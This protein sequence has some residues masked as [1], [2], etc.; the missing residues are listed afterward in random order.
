[1]T[2][3][4]LSI[5]D[6]PPPD[7]KVPRRRAPR[8]R[9]G[10]LLDEAALGIG[11]RPARLIL[12]MVGTVAGIAALV[13]TLGLG[14]TAG[15]QIA[16]RF[17]AAAAT[18]VT[19]TMPKPPG[20][21]GGQNDAAGL[22][23][24]AAER[25]LR[26]AGVSA[27]ATV[28]EVDL[29]QHKVTGVPVVDPAG[30]SPVEI[31]VFA[32]S[33]GLLTAEDGLLSTGRFFDAGHS[34]RADRVVVLGAN[35]ARQLGI[36][37]VDSQPSIF[38]GDQAYL[39]IGILSAADRRS[40]LLD[41]AIIPEGTAAAEFGLTAP[42]QLD[43]R[44]ML[45]AAQQVGRQVGVA[46]SPADPKAAKVKAPPA[47]GT[48]GGDVSQDVNGLFLAFGGVALIVG[49][50]GIANVTLLSVMERTGE[51]GLRRALGAKRRHIT[52]QFL[53][54]SAGIGLIGGLIGAAVGIT[55]VLVVSLTRGWT[56]LLDTRLALAAPV[57][58][59]VIGLLAGAYPALK[60]ATIEPITALRASS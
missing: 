5:L 17:D 43:V 58:G 28:S 42:V 35:A 36:N 25:A 57:I 30:P 1:M 23:W 60:A 46:M 55:T 37:R 3:V 24:D 9:L 19:V 59:I 40:E 53:T 21:P 27:A 10:D 38:I 16:G 56:P 8:L 4:G 6:A 48:L 15:G 50:L 34:G 54:E 45:G 14:Q 13:A 51:I 2:G 22:P 33:P 52:G 29:G 47:P 31:P 12:T 18:R 11:S 49:G 26:L 32:A 41:A 7:P 39:V 44:T 20:P